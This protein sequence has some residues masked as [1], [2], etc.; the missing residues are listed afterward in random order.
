MLMLALE[1]R[2]VRLNTGLAINWAVSQY[3]GYANSVNDCILVY[4]ISCTSLQSGDTPLLCAAPYGHSECVKVLLDRGALVDKQD[5]VSTFPDQTNT[6]FL[7][8]KMQTP[9]L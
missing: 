3:V 6:F 7:T 9:Q 5:K 2:R 8:V 4:T 1:S